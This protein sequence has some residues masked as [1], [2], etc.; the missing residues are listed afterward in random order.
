[1]GDGLTVARFYEQSLVG[2]RAG[3][4][5]SGDVELCCPGTAVCTQQQAIS[6]QSDRMHLGW[7]QV[8]L[9]L[10][11]MRRGSVASVRAVW[12]NTKL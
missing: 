5:V 1:M 7:G 8:L 4:V 9:C 2:S 6:R 10:E 11:G 12:V 3:P